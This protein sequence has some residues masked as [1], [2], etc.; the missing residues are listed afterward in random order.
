MLSQQEVQAPPK[1]KHGA[2]DKVPDEEVESTAAATKTS[3]TN[4]KKEESESK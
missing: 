3:Q 4:E 2:F 1:P